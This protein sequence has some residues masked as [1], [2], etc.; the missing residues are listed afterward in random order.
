T[1]AWN[2]GQLI[3][4]ATSNPS[5]SYI[6]GDHAYAVVNYTAS[7]SMPF[8]VYNPWGGTDSSVWC[9]VDPQVYGLFFASAGFLSQNFASQFI[10]TGTEARLDDHGN[11]SE[12]GA[13]SANSASA[14]SPSTRLSAEVVGNPLRLGSKGKLLNGTDLS[15]QHPMTVIALAPTSS[16]QSIGR[17]HDHL[18]RALGSLMEDDLAFLRS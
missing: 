16:S 6:V 12:E 4:L 18:D 7:S 8:E 15:A 2:A 14:I 10:G 17:Q 1:G 3:V 9:P 5:S 11:S 13:G